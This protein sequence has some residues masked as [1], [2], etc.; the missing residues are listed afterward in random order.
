MKQSIELELRG[1]VFLL[2]VRSQSGDKCFA[3]FFGLYSQRQNQRQIGAVLVLGNECTRLSNQLGN[4]GIQIRFEIRLVMF[5]HRFR[6]EHLEILANNVLTLMAKHFEHGVVHLENDSILRGDDDGVHKSRHH[7]SCAPLGRSAHFVDPREPRG[8]GF[9]IVGSKVVRIFL[10]HKEGEGV[11][12]THKLVVSFQ[13]GRL[14]P[15]NK[16]WAGR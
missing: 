13:D 7:A 9:G 6:H 12:L 11:L 15:N 2:L 14:K 10:R 1:H 8:L 5:G 4:S 3:L 16:L